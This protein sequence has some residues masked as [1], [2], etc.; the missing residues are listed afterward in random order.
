MEDGMGRGDASSNGNCW[1]HAGILI[2]S[3]AMEDDPM[4]DLPPLVLC[5]ALRQVGARNP[6]E[7]AL[8]FLEIEEETNAWELVIDEQILELV[9][10]SAQQPHQLQ[11]I[12]APTETANEEQDQPLLDVKLAVAWLRL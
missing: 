8:A 6:A 2:N 10:G 1:R 5:E 9:S 11:E 3:P 4:D 7:E 12:S